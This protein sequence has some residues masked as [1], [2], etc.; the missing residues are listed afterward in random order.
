MKNIEILESKNII[1]Y[2]FAINYM[3]EKL[4]GVKN[5]TAKELIWFLE[6][7]SIYTSGRGKPINKSYINKIPIYNSG[8]GGKM[9]WHGP[10]QR[11]IYFIIDLKKRGLDIRRFVSNI[12]NFLIASLLELDI[13]AFKKNNVVGIWTLDKEKKE[14]KIGSLGLRVSKGI[15]YHGLSLNVSCDLSNFYKID[16]CGIKDSRVTSIKNLKNLIKKNEVDEVLKRKLKV[17]FY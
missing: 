14:A 5:N 1:D 4:L 9:T 6:H 15:I 2:K 3:E 10:G 11:I 16:P 7:P 17:L 13:K 12:E 8:R